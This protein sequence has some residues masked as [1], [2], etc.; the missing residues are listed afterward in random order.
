MSYYNEI[1]EGYGELHKEEQLKKIK[2]IKEN[3]DVRGRVL[4]IGCGPYFGDFDGFVVGLDNSFELL[5]K[6]KL[7]RVCGVMLVLLQYTMH[8]M[9]RKH[10]WK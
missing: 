7:E 10:L 1:S 4:D 2:I 3:L 6:A 8:L 9:L 5:K